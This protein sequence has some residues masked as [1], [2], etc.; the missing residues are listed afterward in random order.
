MVQLSHIY[1]TYIAD[2][3]V[4]KNLKMDV[5]KGEFVYLMGKSGAGKTTL[6]RLMTGFEKPT[7]GH[8]VVNGY[9]LDKSNKKEILRF[10]RSIGVVFQDFKLLY[11]RSVFDNVALPLQIRQLHSFQIMERVESILHR[12]GL[13]KRMSENPRHLSGGEKQR[14]AIARALVHEPDIIIADE[15]TGNLDWKLSYEIN[16]LFK[17]FNEMGTTVIIATHDDQLVKN[18]PNK[19]ILK[20]ENGDLYES[21]DAELCGPILSP[22]KEI[23]LNIL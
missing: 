4:L 21:G 10:R 3:H 14:V 22:L 9:N 2:Q 19:R 18:T 16:Q 23:G 8:I 20:L 5:A 7:S 15:P 6:F 1:K 11:D 12:V 17:S 13:R